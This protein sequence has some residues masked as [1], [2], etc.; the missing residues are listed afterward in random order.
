MNLGSNICECGNHAFFELRGQRV[1]LISPDDAHIVRRYKPH[2]LH[3]RKAHKY[4]AL[5]INGR[6]TLLH[7][8][9]TGAPSGKVV[10]H[11]NGDGLDNRRHNLRVCDPAQNLWNAKGRSKVTPK[12]VRKSGSKFSAKIMRCGV[13]HY[14]G[15]FSTASEAAAAYNEAALRL[16][17]EYARL[18]I[19]AAE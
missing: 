14:L 3:A 2:M 11:I 15:V 5:S 17:G 10:D 12:G 13:V 18:N 9:L 16:H 4:V 6:K 19:M 8:L 1:A 7:R